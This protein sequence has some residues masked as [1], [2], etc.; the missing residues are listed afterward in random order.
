MRCKGFD[1]T[2]VEAG[3][4]PLGARSV[5]TPRATS[6]DMGC[7]GGDSMLHNKFQRTRRSWHGPCRRDEPPT[8]THTHPNPRSN[9]EAST[10]RA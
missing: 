2:S 10:S 8:H 5:A 9:P 7:Q 3:L 1:A 4:T 6:R